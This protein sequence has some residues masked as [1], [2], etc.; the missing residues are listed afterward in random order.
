MI[1]QKFPLSDALIMPRVYK[2]DSPIYIESHLGV[3]RFNDY[4]IYS[5]SQNVEWVR[6][7]AFFG[8]VH[9]VALDTINNK[10]LGSADP[11]WEGS[12]SDFK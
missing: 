1:K 5:E 12:V 2:Y 8:R 10:W 3:N 4:E 11:D 9:A 6:A 7:E